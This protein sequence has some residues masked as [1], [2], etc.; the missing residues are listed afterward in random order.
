VFDCL[1]GS[2]HRQADTL[3]RRLRS[4]RP[5]LKS[6]RAADG[7]RRRQVSPADRQHDSCGR[8]DANPSE[9][10][11]G[12]K[13][14]FHV[15]RDLP[16]QDWRMVLSFDQR[17]VMANDK[18]RNVQEKGPFLF[19]PGAPHASTNQTG[20]IVGRAL[21]GSRVRWTN[22]MANLDRAFRY[23][24]AVK[25]EYDL[26]AAGG[27]DDPVAGNEFTQARLAAMLAAEEPSTQSIQNDIFIDE[28]EVFDQG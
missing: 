19:A 17:R 28:V 15:G 5:V 13:A 10:S 11:D 7:P 25:L 20:V 4:H 14:I 22:R 8:A 23:E 1:A 24:N 6:V 9:G 16:E 12:I 18:S 26:F 27:V 3:A 21:R 2:I